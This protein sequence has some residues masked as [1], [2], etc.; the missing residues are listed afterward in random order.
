MAIPFSIS[1][2]VKAEDNSD[3]AEPEAK[4]EPEVKDDPEG[5]GEAASKTDETD[6]DALR[7]M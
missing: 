4:K 2:P 5:E 6:G 1:T 3:T 7:P